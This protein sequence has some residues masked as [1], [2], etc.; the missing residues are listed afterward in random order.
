MPGFSVP[1]CWQASLIFAAPRQWP[2]PYP[3]PEGQRNEAGLPIFRKEI[4][5]LIVIPILRQRGAPFKLCRIQSISID[6]PAK[7]QPFDHAPV[8]PISP[9]V[10]KTVFASSLTGLINASIKSFDFLISLIK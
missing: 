4:P 2:G 8:K 6:K 7:E 5:Q 3:L 9:I 1:K 10:C